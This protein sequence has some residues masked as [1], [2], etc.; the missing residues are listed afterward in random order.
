MKRL[1]AAI[2]FLTR[3]PLPA[4]WQFDAADVGRATPLFPLVGAGLGAVSAATLFALAWLPPTLAAVLLVALAAWL[5]G[6]LHMDG[7]ADT[8]DGFGGGRTREDALRIMR[9]HC[10]GTYGAVALIL[11]IVVK[12]LAI[13]ALIER[14]AALPYLILAPALGRWTT[15]A[16][17]FLLPYARRGEGGL[18]AAVTDHVGWAELSEATIIAGALTLFVAGRSGAWCW[19]VVLVVTAFNA[20]L[21]RRKIGGVTGDTLG[22]NT[23]ACEAAVFVL[24]VALTS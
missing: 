16:L 20:R 14:D 6:A 9:D 22:A 11:L 23:E 8:A 3:A 24:A 15:V 4:H 1:F 7:L 17:S 18:G 12:V 19:L 13:G 2:A 21:C 5:T 10:I